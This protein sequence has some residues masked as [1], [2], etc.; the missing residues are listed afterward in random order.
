MGGITSHILSV[1][2]AFRDD[3]EWEIVIAT[4]PGKRKDRTLF[5]RAGAA[6]FEVTAFEMASTFD[7]AVRGRLREYVESNDIGAVHT[8]AY[9]ANVIANLSSLSVPVMTTSHGLA[10]RPTMRLRLWQSM[11]LRFMR[12][13]RTVITCSAF[14]SKTLQ[15]RGVTAEEFQVIYNASSGSDPNKT[16]LSRADLNIEPNHIIA[17]YVG[18]LDAGKR[19]DLLLGSME[20]LRNYHLVILGDGPERESLERQAHHSRVSI[21]FVGAVADPSPYY[22]LADVVVLP[23]EMEA[24]PMTLIEA[25]AY[26]NPV[27]AT[28]VGGVGEVVLN[29]ETGILV[30]GVE[31]VD[32]W[33]DALERLSDEGTRTRFGAV[34]RARHRDTFSLESLRSGL[35]SVYEASM[36]RD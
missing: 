33:V 14:V 20:R 29:G 12:S 2:E 23:T 36:G 34:A 24:L 26:G 35:A 17:L 7:T 32:G 27:I 3:P 16:K 22:H 30:D 28:N 5:D 1:A 19:V 6:G 8:H 9:R 4:L 13:Q 10:V 15:D 11:H 25:A 31:D 21:T 18:R